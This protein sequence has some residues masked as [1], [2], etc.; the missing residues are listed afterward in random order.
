MLSSPFHSM[1]Y[2]EYTWPVSPLSISPF[3]LGV[4]YDFAE[5]EDVA[6][7]CPPRPRWEGLRLPDPP[8][9]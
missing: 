5:E 3:L 2:A 6:G 1:A 9:R 4:P 8:Q 7:L